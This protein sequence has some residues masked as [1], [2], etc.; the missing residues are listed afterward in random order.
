MEK[1]HSFDFCPYCGFKLEGIED[2][3]PE[4]GKKLV[5]IPSI[6][7]P[8]IPDGIP[9]V[10]S[11]PQVVNNTTN[12]EPIVN[13]NNAQQQNSQPIVPHR[14]S[15]KGLVWGIVAIVFVA[16]LVGGYFV[17]QHQGYLPGTNSASNT[18]NEVVVAAKTNYFIAYSSDYFNGKKQAVVSNIVI[19]QK[20]NETSDWV[21]QQMSK[22]ITKK[23]PKAKNHFKSVLVKTYKSLNEATTGSKGIKDN[24]KKQGFQIQSIKIAN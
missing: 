10:N 20:P 5:N 13:T 2:F 14:K 12:K 21:K 6:T 24:Y 19:A 17:L 1:K 9:P 7:P 22:S 8:P 15:N 11:N 4:C 16:V 18:K 23:M 3:C